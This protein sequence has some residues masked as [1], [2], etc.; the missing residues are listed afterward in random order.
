MDGL[1]LILSSVLALCS[2]GCLIYMLV[3]LAHEKG[4][5]HALLGFLF[6]IYPF[7][8]GWVNAGRLGIVDVMGF[9]TA[10]IVIYTGFS[11]AMMAVAAQSMQF[12]P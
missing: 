12:L 9:W 11:L 3:R 4:A 2:L 6:P 10:V 7:F 8:W 5:L 1:D